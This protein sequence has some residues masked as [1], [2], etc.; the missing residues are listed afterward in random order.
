[1]AR[2]G[3]VMHMTWGRVRAGFARIPLIARMRLLTRY[4][5]YLRSGQTSPGDSTA[6]REALRTSRGKALDDAA[7][8]AKRVYPAS[9][10]DFYPAEAIATATEVSR[11]GY[12]VKEQYVS[13]ESE[14]AE[15]AAAARRFIQGFGGLDDMMPLLEGRID[16]PTEM[17]FLPEEWVLSQ[18]L[19]LKLLFDPFILGTANEYLGVSPVLSQANAWFSFRSDKS[20]NSLSAQQWHWD[21][22]RIRWLKVF[23]YIGDVNLEDGPHEFVRGTHRVLPPTSMS[24][25]LEDQAVRSKFL[26]SDIISFNAP[27]GTV[28]FEDTRGLHRG[29][30]VIRGHRLVL[31]LEFSMDLFGAPTARLPSAVD[32]AFADTKVSGVWP[33]L[34]MR[35]RGPIS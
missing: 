24:S 11:D 14:L 2:R 18:N 26:S 17:L 3:Y 8:V 6:I 29:R 28:I 13:D 1:L 22:D 10:R 34:D 20:S 33:R 12:A 9:P 30:P 4:R 7:N 32:D 19:T 16:A 23:L 15:F 5:R 25:R 31:Q 35:N 27:A 21:C